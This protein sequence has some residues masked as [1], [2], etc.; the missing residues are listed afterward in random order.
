MRIALSERL[1]SLRETYGMPGISAAILF[2]DGSMWR[3]SSGLADVEAGR[4]VT[5]ETQ[6]AVASISKTFLAARILRLIETGD[7]GLD[8]P[9]NTYLP[10]LGLDDGITVRRLLDHT[11]GIHDYFYDPDID[12]ALLADRERVWTT[13]DVLG[14]VGKPYFK[15]GRGWHYSNTNYVILGLLAERVAGESLAA[16]LRSE[17]FDPLGLDHTHYQGFEDPRGLLASAYRFNGPDLDEPPIPLGDGTEVVPFT[18]VVTAAGSAGSVASTAEDL[19]TWARALYDGD[20]LTSR[21]RLVMVADVQVTAPFEPSIPYGLG[22][23]AATVD[24]RPTLGHSGRLLG[25]RT[26]VRWLPEERMAIAVLTNQSRSDPNLL[27]RALVRVALGIPADCTSC[28][29]TN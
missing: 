11:S 7:L 13:D 22:V 21:S 18:S 14:Y 4:P 6:F 29:A 12:E 17:F 27:V 9:V 26:V 19:V 2:A 3:G 23:Q 25:S 28:V 20:V 10:D 8:T 1:D 24:G 5:R 15:P 16:Q